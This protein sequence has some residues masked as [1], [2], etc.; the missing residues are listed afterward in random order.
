MS[1]QAELKSRYL[2]MFEMLID[3]AFRGKPIPFLFCDGAYL[4]LYLGEDEELHW[5][6]CGGVTNKSAGDG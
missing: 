1:M 2:K 5:R 6:I 3:Q 4:E